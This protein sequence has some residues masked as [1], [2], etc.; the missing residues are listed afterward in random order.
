MDMTEK[1]IV[2][3]INRKFN[4][5]CVDYSLLDDD[6]KILIALSGGKDSLMLAKLLSGRARIFKPCISV[7]AA[8][9][10]MDNIPYESDIEYLQSFCSDLSI[11]LHILHTRF[12]ESTDKRKTKCFLCAWQRRKALFQ[13]AENGGFN[14]VALGHHQDDIIVT[15]LMNAFYSGNTTTMFPRLKMKHYAIDLI[16]PM[17]LVKEEWIAL[18]SEYLHFRKQKKKCPYEEITQRASVAEIFRELEKVNPEVRHNLWRCS[19]LNVSSL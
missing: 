7:E 15:W 10:V 12:D 4:Q 14:K 18:A 2:T 17:C 11:P 19:L 3:A 6:D 16:R 9:V 8:H 5:G 13:F 1:E